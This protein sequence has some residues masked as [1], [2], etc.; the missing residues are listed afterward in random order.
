MSFMLESGVSVLGLVAALLLALELGRRLG[1][2][3][4][5]ADPEGAEKGTGAVEGAVFALMGL[6][7]AFT[8]SGALTR[9]ELRRELITQEANAIGTAWLRLD[10]LPPTQRENLRAEFKHYLEVRIADSVAGEA[11]ASP[12]VETSQEKIWREAMV[13]APS[14]PPPTLGLVLQ[15][16]NDM[17]DIAGARYAA[18]LNHAS[19]AVY[20]LLLALAFLSSLLAGYGMAG[21]KTRSWLHIVCFVTSLLISIFVIVDTEFPRRGL[22]NLERFDVKLTGL[23]DS[24]K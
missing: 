2:A 1:R 6:L 16:L 5:L 8:L 10:L 20:A 18:A 24:L 3:R 9:F 21:A 17:F 7:V 4:R 14:L 13:A 15:P 11:Q 23:R 22:I 12:A 19:P